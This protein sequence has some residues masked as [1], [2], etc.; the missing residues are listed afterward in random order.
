[1]TRG[2]ESSAW[3]GL[4]RGEGGIVF[5]SVFLPFMEEWSLFDVVHLYP[6]LQLSRK[7]TIGEL[8]ILR[9]LVYFCTFHFQIY[10]EHRYYK[11]RI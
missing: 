1:M 11:D 3:F 10:T 8:Y 9:V 4:S 2:Q 5:L 7:M 6:Q